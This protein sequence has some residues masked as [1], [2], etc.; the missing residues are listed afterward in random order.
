M[1][2]YRVFLLIIPQ[3]A[4]LHGME[5]DDKKMEK[6]IYS[7]PVGSSITKMRSIIQQNDDISSNASIV[8]Q[9]TSIQEI[10]EY[11]GQLLQI[12]KRTNELLSEL[13]T[14]ESNK[15]DE[16]LRMHK[17]KKREIEFNTAATICS[18]RNSLGIGSP[19]ERIKSDFGAWS[20]IH[21][22]SE[23]L[24]NKMR[25]EMNTILKKQEE[26][27]KKKKKSKKLDTARHTKKTT[28]RTISHHRKQ[29]Q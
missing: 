5:E 28:P 2:K 14:I 19:H 29:S 1:K 8:S 10:A 26:S 17:L 7:S 22:E 9:D 18:L 4:F 16:Q 15:R 3:I 23:R 25:K 20:V 13:I 27:Q 24:S 21:K 12:N 11:I 6:K